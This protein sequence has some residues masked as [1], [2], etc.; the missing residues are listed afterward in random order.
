MQ[1][2][3]VAVG[4]QSEA[5]RNAF[6]R[7]T[8]A[9]LLLAVLAFIGIEVYL[10]QTGLAQSMAQAMLS[11]NW[12]FILG[13]FVLLSWLATHFAQSSQNKG[14]QYLGL[15]LYVILQAIIFVPMLYIAQ[16][17]AGGGVIETAG[18]ATIIG[19]AGLTLIAFST[20]TDFSFLG[21]FLLWGGLGAMLLII[22]GSLFGFHLGTFFSVAMIIFAGAAILYDTSNII[23]HFGED[24]YVAASLQLFASVAM[25][26]FYLLRFFSG[27][28]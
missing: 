4:Y 11:V 14:M 5:T 19:F 12:L 25:L 13:G 21:K 6:I 1:S 18:T 23:H 20:R 2:S 9:H 15:G 8:Y 28:D 17:K 3:T 7:K 27:R 22:C 10:F 26:F 16:A 24:Q